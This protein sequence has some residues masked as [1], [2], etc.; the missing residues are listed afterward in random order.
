M[1]EHFN[2]ISKTINE[3]FKTLYDAF[4]EKI[5]PILKDSYNHIVEALSHL[6]DEILNTIVNLFSRLI[7]S[8]KKF[9]ED[10]KKIG[11]S[12]NEWAQKMGQIL[13]EQWAIVRREFEDILKLI[14]DYLKAL[15]GLEV[16]KEKYNE[17]S[18][19]QLDF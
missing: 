3:F 17:V 2:Q 9:E 8:L 19:N 13:N 14:F 7:D 16:I 11:K 1:I 15:P 5:L 4:N 12:V 10:F 6:F 18:Q